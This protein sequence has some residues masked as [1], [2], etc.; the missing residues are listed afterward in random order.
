[1]ATKANAKGNC[2]RTKPTPSAAVAAH[3]ARSRAMAAGFRAAKAPKAHPSTAAI[4]TANIKL[5]T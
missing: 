3:K 2:E 5:P 1:M 4:S